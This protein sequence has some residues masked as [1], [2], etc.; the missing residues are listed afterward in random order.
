MNNSS[1]GRPAAHS[2]MRHSRFGAVRRLV[3]SGRRRWVTP[4]VMLVLLLGIVAG[5]IIVSSVTQPHVQLDDGTVWVTSLKDHKAARFNVKNRDADAGVASKAARFDIAQHDGDTVLSEGTKASNIAASTVSESG[6]TTMTS[7][8]ETVVGG[9]TVALFN[10]KTGNVWVGSASDVKSMNPTADAP[11]MKLGAGGAIAVTHDGTVYGYRASDHTVMSVDGPQ[12]TLATVG[13]IPGASSAESFTVVGGTPVV[14]GNGKVFWP[15]GNVTIGLTGR[16]VLQAPSTDGRQRDWVAVSTPRGIATVDLR[17]KKVVPLSNSGKGDAARPVST[18]GCVFAAWSQRANNYVS[19]CDARGVSAK[20]SSLESVNPTSQLVFRTNHRLVVLNDVI[21]GNV[22][23]PQESTKVIKIQWN[24]VDTKQSKQQ[25]QNNDSANNQ[26][27]FSKT[28]SSQSGQIKAQDDAFGA[29]TGSQQILDVLRN[30]EQTD[31]SALRIDSVSAPDGA[32]IKVSPIYDGRYLQLDASAASAGSVTFSYTISDGRGQT[33]SA[34]VSLDL[35]AGAN[36]APLQIDTPPEFDVE[37]GASTT[38]NALGSFRD[39]DGDPLTLVSATPQN[40]DQVT[41]STRADGQLVFNAGSMSSGRAGIEVTVSD[42]LQIGTGMIYFSVKPANTLAATIDPV[43]RQTTPDTRTTIALKQ[44]VHG[45]SLEPA[46]LTAVESPAGV[47]ATMNATDMSITFSASDPGTYYV[48]YTITQGSVPTT[49][50]VRVDVQAVTGDAAKPIAANDVAL[51]GADNT[52]IVE[53]LTNDVDPLGGV[54]SVTSVAAD[55]QSGIKTGIVGNK[56]VYITARRVPTRPVQLTY[57]VANAAGSSTGVITLQ[58]PALTSSNSVPKAGNITAQVRTGGIV[59]VDVLDHVTYSDGTT[60]KLQN[61]LEVDKHTFKGLVFVSGDTVR[62]QASRQTGSFPVTY[63]VK[64][65]LGNTASATITI[66]VHEKDASNKAAPTPADVEAQVAAGQKV[67]IPVT[68]TGI[69][70]DGDDVQLLGLGNKAP[71]LGRIT[72]VGATY[73]VYEAYADSTGTD[74][75]SYAVEDWT[76]QRATAQIRVGVFSSGA[77]SGVYARDDEITLRPNTATT[78]PVAQNDISGDS[79]DLTVGKHVESQGISGISVSDNMLSFTTPKQPGTYYVVYTVNNKAGLSDTATLTVN[80]DGNAPIDP[81][82]AYDYRVPAAAT[83]DKK[84]VDVDVSQWIANPSGTADELQVG[85]DPS[86]A[87]HAHVKDGKGSTTISVDLTDETRA[88]PYT[89]TNTTYGITSTAFIQV[90]AYGVFPPTLRPK[91]PALKV[92]AHETITINIADYVRVGAGKTAYVDGAGSVSATKAAN[93]DLYVN[94]QTLRF[95]APKDY[96]G[97]ASITFTA[98]DGKRS[99]GDSVKIVNSAVLTLPI[100]VIGR[101]VPAPTFSSPTVDVAAGESATTIDLTALTHSPSGL[102]DDEKQYTYAG[103][104]NSNGVD[105]KVSAAGK[106]TISASKTAAPGTMVSVPVNITYAKGTVNAG[107]TVRVTAS[108]RPLARI[109][110]KTV[111]IKAGSSQQVNMLADA[112]NPFPD[113]PLTVTD[114]TADK[115]AKFIVTCPSNGVISITASSDIGASNNTVVVTVRD[116][117]QTRERETTGTINVA[118][119]DKPDAPLLSAVSTKPQDGRIDL[120]WTAGSANGSPITEYKVLWSG[121]GSGERSCGAATSCTIDG[122]SNGKT[123]TFKVRAKN[124]VGWSK[125]SNAVEGTP[126]KLPDAPTDVSIEGGERTITV[127]WKAPSGNF[128]AIDNYRVTLSG[129]NAPAP[130]ETTGTS[131]T[132]PIDDNAIIDGV[133]YKATVQS[134]NKVNWSQPSKQ[135]GDAKPWGKPDAPHITV[136]NDDT[137]GTLTVE[138]VGNTRNAGCKTVELSGDL[139]F[140]VACNG[141]KTFDI[142]EHD[143]NTKEYTV[144]ASVVGDKAT[145]SDPATVKFTPHYTVETPAS[146]KVLGKGDTCKVEWT[147]R[148][149]ADGFTVQAAGFVPY[150]AEASERSHDFTLAPWQACTTGSVAQMFNGA[151]SDMVADALAQPYVNKKKAQITVPSLRW[152]AKDANIIDVDGGVV[153]T[154]GQAGTSAIVFKANGKSW[155]VAWTPGTHALDVKDLLP[156]GADYTWSVN[157]TG[158][159][160]ALSNAKD[161]GRLLDNDRVAPPAPQPDPSPNSSA[162]PSASPTTSAKPAEPASVRMPFPRRPGIRILQSQDDATAWMS[163]RTIAAMTTQQQG[164]THEH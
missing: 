46:Q 161:G 133:S 147:K 95:T 51:L 91:A 82:T 81:P 65:N 124:E 62:Y 113:T 96:A 117:T 60:V 143:L 79:T 130:K 76:G 92:N 55:S 12:G 110:G 105:A 152:N 137:K 54:L 44:Y 41:V 74:T 112:Y 61:N 37:Q 69:D 146:V 97:P 115:G 157:V 38:V 5:A 116:A 102:Y 15:S 28:C 33:S 125:E 67:Q 50:L 93:N 101:D 52:A 156:A 145:R 16:A 36:R 48:P 120:N 87:D 148:G 136:T 103:G 111:N 63:T 6:N 154:Y 21:N 119:S 123:Y 84:S 49:G 99:K 149:H 40:T 66:N 9:S 39:P 58:P 163:T 140:T 135:S 94:D 45:T 77:D 107:V 109:S 71:K 22:W 56:R 47:S 153:T 151:A 34:N 43:V 27:H 26:R 129:T 59:S 10:A 88:V 14:A 7:D 31:C 121:A 64:D 164:A 2:P 25:E 139:D 158:A 83:I 68:L 70:P 128:S 127:T 29:R 11:N 150:V 72:E 32:D 122:L 4:V 17:S 20:F 108:N 106:L 126:D 141:S 3:S 75:F 132:F 80:V 159:D 100:T 138:S 13:S 85:V 144:H 160:P 30:D 162:N 42:G 134:H 131:V 89:V 35:T 73:L 53:P 57:T 1:M 24:K 23:N 78:V 155:T 8:M 90:P 19:V 118:V 104:A 98:A 142:P 18:G 114:C 86:A